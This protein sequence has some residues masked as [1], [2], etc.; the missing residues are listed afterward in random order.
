MKTQVLQHKNY[1]L[2]TTSKNSAQN[3]ICMN[4]CHMMM[5]MHR[6]RNVSE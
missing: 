6:C 2:F 3:R 4:R 5:C 1:N